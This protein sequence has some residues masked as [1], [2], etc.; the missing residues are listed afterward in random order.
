MDVLQRCLH[1]LV[2]HTLVY[3]SS[4]SILTA[5]APRCHN[6]RVPQVIQQVRASSSSFRAKGFLALMR[7]TPRGGAAVTPSSI[8]KPREQ[9]VFHLPSMQVKESSAVE[10]QPIDKDPL[11]SFPITKSEFPHFAAMSF[12]MFLFIYVFTTVRDT[13]DTLVV[14]N[15]GAE[16]IPFLKLYGVM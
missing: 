6:D 4:A 7:Q 3:Y 15:C 2:V 5:H 12:M 13:K 14:S 11:R 16:A 9:N 1:F 8:T 10:R